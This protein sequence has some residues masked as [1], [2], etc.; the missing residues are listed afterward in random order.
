LYDQ[1]GDWRLAFAAYNAGERAVQRAMARSGSNDYRR[2]SSLLPGETRAY[3]PAVLTA[4]VL[5]DHGPDTDDVK[6]QAARSALVLY[7]AAEVNGQ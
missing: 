1:F 5:F 3:V 2:L 6:L 7:A 4:R